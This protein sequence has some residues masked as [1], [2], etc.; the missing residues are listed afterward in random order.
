MTPTNSLDI[1]VAASAAIP[2]LWIGIGLSTG[3]IGAVVRA[4]RT[5][6][7]G[8]IVIRAGATWRHPLEL[9]F[10]VSPLAI[11]VNGVQLGT[12]TVGVFFALIVV[13][14]LYGEVV[15][16]YALFDSTSALW[17]RWS[18]LMSAGVLALLTA[19]VL[20]I[21]IATIATAREEDAQ[22]PVDGVRGT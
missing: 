15:A 17:T 19:T 7:S 20:A 21:S 12:S 13:S 11:T 6:V 9:S 8:Q 16:L 3:A 14:G 2:V 18:V 22:T 10:S 1:Y 4:L 5:T